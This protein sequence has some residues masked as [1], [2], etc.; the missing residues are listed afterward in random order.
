MST[1]SRRL[2]QKARPSRN[3]HTP[4]RDK[5]I[6]RPRDHGIAINGNPY[7]GHGITGNHRN[8]WITVWGKYYVRNG[9]K[10]DFNP[11][12]EE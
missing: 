4:S 7:K 8:T 3:S 11:P 9:L 2:S 10:R 6:K 5:K 1:T 12:N